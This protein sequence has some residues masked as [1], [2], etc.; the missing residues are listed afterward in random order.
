[1]NFIMNTGEIDR[2]SGG[3]SQEGSYV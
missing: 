1:M 2:D 3:Q